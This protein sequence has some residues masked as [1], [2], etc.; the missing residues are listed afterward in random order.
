MVG[1]VPGGNR[2]IE[3]IVRFRLLGRNFLACI[4]EFHSRQ[5]SAVLID[6]KNRNSLLIAAVHVKELPVGRDF[7]SAVPTL[8]ALGHDRNLLN[9]LELSAGRL[10]RDFYPL[11]LIVR[12]HPFPVWVD[13]QVPRTVPLLNLDIRR[14]ERRNCR[15]L[16]VDFVGV[17]T[18]EALIGHVE[19]TVIRGEGHSVSMR[20][21]VRAWA[22]MPV[23]AHGLAQTSVRQNAISNQISA[24]VITQGQNTPRAIHLNMRRR[25]SLCVHAIEKLQASCRRIDRERGYS[26]MRGCPGT[27]RRAGNCSRHAGSHKKSSVGADRKALRSIRSCH[28]PQRCELAA[29]RRKPPTIDSPGVL[30]MSPWEAGSSSY[31]HRG[32]PSPP[33]EVF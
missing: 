19:Q 5:F 22:A 30:R 17:N 26:G 25:I 23:D 7:V 10:E 21:S 11:L 9:L 8:H 24:V 28:Q 6:G 20:P 29:R 18:V 32:V 14:I 31:R 33:V 27:E 3:Q 4:R 15:T 2:G 12:V 13:G 16:N 1:P